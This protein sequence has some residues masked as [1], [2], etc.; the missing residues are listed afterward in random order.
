MPDVIIN[1]DG[2]SR[3]NPGYAALGAVIK[4]GGETKTYA[5]SIGTKTNNEAEYLAIIFALKKVK[6]LI[7]KEKSARLSLEVRSDSELIVSQ[8]NGEYKLK[9]KNLVPMFVEVWNLKQDFGKIK[10]VH[11]GREENKQADALLNKELNTPRLL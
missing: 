3:G 7:G 2:G 11:I 9:D 6:Q 10:F 8:I 1:T 4:Y 5:Q